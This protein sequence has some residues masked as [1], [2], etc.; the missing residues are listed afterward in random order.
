MLAIERQRNIIDIIDKIGTVYVKNLAEEFD[1]SRDTIRNDLT[2]LENQGLLIK[3]YGGAIKKGT[4]IHDTAARNRIYKYVEEKKRIAKK[5]FKLIKPNSLIY[6]DFSTN[7]IYLAELLIKVDFEVVVVTTMLEIADILKDVNNVELILVGGKLNKTKEGFVG[8]L[9]NEW[10][11]SFNFDIAFLGAVGIDY[12]KDYI[13]T[14]EIEDASTKSYII[15]LSNKSYSLLESRKCYL[16][17]NRV[18]SKLSDLDGIIVD[19]KLKKSSEENIRKI[20]VD[21]I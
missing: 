21:V 6:L 13:Y 11:S 4:N 19:K 7:C 15:N 9:T 3:T 2:N 8:S 1:V 18:Y 14:Y 12:D 5:A 16:T 10:L 17:G 20:G